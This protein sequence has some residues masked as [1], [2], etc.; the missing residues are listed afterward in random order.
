MTLWLLL[1][2]DPPKD[3]SACTAATLGDAQDAGISDPKKTIKELHVNRGHAS[4]TQLKRALVDSANGTSHL[5]PRVDEV[6][7]NCDVCRAFDK[8]PHVPIAG[9]TTASAFNEKAQAGLPFLGD[10]RFPE[11]LSSSPCATRKSSGSSRRFF[12]Q[13][14]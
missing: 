9:A 8:A 1:R 14:G 5:V 6:L 11:I 12:A 13:D 7:E 10:G 4:A 2:F 3:F